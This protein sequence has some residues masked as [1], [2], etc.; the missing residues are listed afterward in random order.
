MGLLMKPIE[1]IALVLSIACAL[2]D[3]RAGAFSTQQSTHA[4]IP[5][6][7]YHS[8]RVPSSSSSSLS[9]V[10]FDR[11]TE[12]WI[13][14]RDEESAEAGYG[15]AG[16]LLRS[17]PLPC[18][19]RVTNPDKYDQAVLKFMAQD[20]CDR[21]EAQGNMDAFFANPNDWQYQ[22][23]QEKN[24]GAPKYDYANARSN[25][26]DVVLTVTWALIVVAWFA[27][28]I[29]DCINGKYSTGG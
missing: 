16:S 17:G 29:N 14:D 28:F 12:R 6:T 8:F 10:S 13:P 26:K 20:L 2:V 1:I 18:F 11:Q 24:N 25:P 5:K 22:R 23:L 21:N 3:N 9:M 15:L 7:Y 27:N 19:K 4:L